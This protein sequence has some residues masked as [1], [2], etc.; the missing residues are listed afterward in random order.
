MIYANAC[1]LLSAAVAAPL[2]RDSAPSPALAALFTPVRPELGRYEVCTSDATL[3]G[4]AESLDA[5]DA[6][7]T[8]GPYSR[9]SLQQ[10]YAG[11]RVR[12]VRSWAARCADFVATTQLSPHP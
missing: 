9:A 4:D 7:G 2:T 10:L 11:A 3:D 8:A 12:V 5:L 1:I 6:F